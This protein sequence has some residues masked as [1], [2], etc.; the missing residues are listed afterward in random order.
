MAI[1]TLGLDLEYSYPKG[2]D[3]RP[4]SELHVRIIKNV[5]DRAKESYGELSK[6]MI[7]GML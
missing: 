6:S 7:T 4:S 1:N 2:L 3:L 5:L